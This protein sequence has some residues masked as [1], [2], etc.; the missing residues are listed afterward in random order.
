MHGI[1]VALLVLMGLLLP[2]WIATRRLT[3]RS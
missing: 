1:L 2:V 3:K